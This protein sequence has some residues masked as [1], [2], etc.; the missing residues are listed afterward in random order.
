MSYTDINQLF[1]NVY[2][3]NII[4]ESDWPAPWPMMRTE[5]DM[6]MNSQSKIC[7]CCKL[8]ENEVEIPRPVKYFPRP[9][10]NPILEGYYGVPPS[11]HYQY[12]TRARILALEDPDNYASFEA[13]SLF[14]Y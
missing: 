11:Q 2:N 13:T 5:Y 3:P 14:K 12:G 4:P 7:D 10:T 8:N 9:L 1:K 6:K